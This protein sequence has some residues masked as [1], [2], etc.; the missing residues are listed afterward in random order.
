MKLRQIVLISVCA[1]AALV[2]AL[3]FVLRQGGGGSGAVSSRSAENSFSEPGANLNDDVSPQ[4]LLADYKEWSKYPPDSR[5]LT[6][7]HVDVIEHRKVSLSWQRMPLLRPD[8]SSQPT[9]F[10]CRLQPERHTVVESEALR[11]TLACTRE[12]STHPVALHIERSELTKVVGTTSERTMSPTP[13]DNGRDGD[14]KAGDNVYTFQFKPGP[15]DWGDMILKLGFRIE[16]DDSGFLHSLAANFFSSPGAPA[17][18]TGNFREKLENGSLIVAAEIQVKI[19]GRYTIEGNLVQEND[20]VAYA[21]K[22]ARLGTGLQWVELTYFGKIFHDE[23]RQGKFQVTGLRGYLDTG[24]IDP[25]VLAR[26]PEEV[27]RFLK[28]VRQTE[29]PRRMIP[30][31]SGRHETKEYTLKDFSNAEYDSE[32][33]RQRIAQLEARI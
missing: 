6:V 10:L 21:R 11:I 13:V 17:V 14:E 32:I 2:G 3:F 4:R 25:D 31:F 22:D 20:P 19:G 26:S 8:G 28:N 16:G 30:Y 12:G 1:G 24:A 9:G 5:P 15:R 33:K 29:P 18:F 7:D 23:D 27:D